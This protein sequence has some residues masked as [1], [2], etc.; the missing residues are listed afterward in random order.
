MSLTLWDTVNLLGLGIDVGAAL[1][2][3]I[4]ET[5]WFSSWYML[6]IIIPHVKSRYTIP[7][8]R[9]MNRLENGESVEKTDQGFDALIEAIRSG[10]ETYLVSQKNWS[11]RTRTGV[12]GI[13][14]EELAIEGLRESEPISLRVNDYSGEPVVV[15]KTKSQEE[16][17]VAT[18]DVLNSRT[19]ELIDEKI[20]RMHDMKSVFV[21][22]AFV[23]GFIL[24]ALAYLGTSLS[25]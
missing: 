10:T 17:Q 5:S 11:V 21:T 9:G 2:L 14:R 7:I 15:A 23:I 25:W 1:L 18:M 12:H 4:V 20:E 16:K 3:T 8:R 19:D 24:Q 13:K 22:T 6:F